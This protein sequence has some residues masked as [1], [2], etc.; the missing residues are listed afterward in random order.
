MNGEMRLEDGRI[1]LTSLAETMWKQGRRFWWLLLL[2]AGIGA[3]ACSFLVKKTY[4]PVY[5]AFAAY[6][7]SS[8]SV[9]AGNKN[10]EQKVA[11]QIGVVYAR[12]FLQE[13]INWLKEFLVKEN[14]TVDD[15]HRVQEL[16]SIVPY[17]GDPLIKNSFE[18][19]IWKAGEN[20]YD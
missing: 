8:D 6:A 18:V 11:E 13:N 19:L 17:I 12:V 10:Y 20:I 4:Q 16:K 2:L 5:T 9:Y 15:K 1:D 14:K 7:V 3:A